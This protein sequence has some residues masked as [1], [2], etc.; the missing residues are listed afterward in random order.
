MKF[1]GG[2]SKP[3]RNHVTIVG[4]LYSFRTEN[5]LETR[6]NVYKNHAF[7]HVE[8]SKEF[9]KTLR[10]NHG[11]KSLQIPFVIHADTESLLEENTD[12]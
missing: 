4:C 12:M 1:K 6:E 5:K 7:C 9:D 2:T 8:M 11:Q 10:Y 3:Q